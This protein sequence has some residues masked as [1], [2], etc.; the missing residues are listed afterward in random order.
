V[1]AAFDIYT[2]ITCPKNILL[3]YGRRYFNIVTS[4]ELNY[5]ILVFIIIRELFLCMT[6]STP[7]LLIALLK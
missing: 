3:A 7:F 5:M 6:S 1:A 2:K 4:M